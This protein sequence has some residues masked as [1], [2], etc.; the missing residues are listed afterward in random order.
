MTST[1]D[2]TKNIQS[3][4]RDAK[5]HLLPKVTDTPMK[6]ILDA[7]NECLKAIRTKHPEVPNAILVIGPASQKNYG[8]FAPA[9]W[10]GKAPQNEITLNGEGLLRGAEAT[11]GTLIHECA[12]ALAFTRDVKDT[13]RQG[14]FHNKRFKVVAEELGI[15]IQH[16]KAIGWSITTLPK[17]TALSYKAELAQLKKALS[18][19]RLTKTKPVRNKTTIKL[20]TASGRSVVVPISFYEAGD[21]KDKATGQLFKPV[22]TEEDTEDE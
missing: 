1:T 9:S 19:F 5:G 11:L 14:R 3:M 18:T 20:V 17:D 21:I 13:S 2:T 4:K 12:H 8:H 7:L 16:D 10:D 6:P 15:E 22:E